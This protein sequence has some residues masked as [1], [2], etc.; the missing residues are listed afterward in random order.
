[1]VQ[2]SFTHRVK[3]N[4]K[5][6]TGSAKGICFHLSS[7]SVDSGSSPGLAVIFADYEKSHRSGF[8]SRREPI[9]WLALSLLALLVAPTGFEPVL[10]G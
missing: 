8:K 2:I 1:M 4:K 6:P 7:A 9:N 10:H 3:K 5:N